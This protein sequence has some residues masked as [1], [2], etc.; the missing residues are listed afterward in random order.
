MVGFRVVGH[1]YTFSYPGYHS[2]YMIADVAASDKAAILSLQWVS[3]PEVAP[4]LI[5]VFCSYNC[6]KDMKLCGQTKYVQGKNVTIP[7]A[8]INLHV[9]YCYLLKA[10]GIQPFWMQGSFTIRS[11]RKFS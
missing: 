1:I 8:K 10:S 11:R 2:R 6:T 9:R 7:L 5:Q 3:Q 4:D